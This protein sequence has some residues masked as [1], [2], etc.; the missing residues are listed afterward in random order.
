M[1]ICW[2][3]SSEKRRV[4]I[5][6]ISE[7]ARKDGDVND[8]YEVFTRMVRSGQYNDFFTKLGVKLPVKSKTK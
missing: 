8:P 4:T 7:T 6:F 2:I 5:L 3:A 1:R